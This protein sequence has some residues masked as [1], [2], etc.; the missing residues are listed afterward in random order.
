MV[1]AKV[2]SNAE[3][4]FL[5]AHYSDTHTRDIA[6][7]L[8][9]TESSVK[10]KATMLG[11]KA[12]SRVRSPVEQIQQ[13]KADGLTIAEIAGQLR[14]TVHQVNHG[15][16]HGG[17][18]SSLYTPRR[19]ARWTEERVAKLIRLA[20]EKAPV[21]IIAEK[22]GITVPAVRVKACNLK[23]QLRGGKKSYSQLDIDLAYQMHEAGFS[24][25]KIA[26]KL[27]D[28]PI[29]LCTVRRI[30]SNESPSWERT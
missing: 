15:L 22:L 28:P 24:A 17:S 30:L 20:K 5:T 18:T 6:A 8:D 12:K 23:I 19:R 10:S 4:T 3:I 25:R 27:D 21:N 7:A 29:S 2:W 14:L 11:L 9:R 1:T 26:A 13:L 16:Y